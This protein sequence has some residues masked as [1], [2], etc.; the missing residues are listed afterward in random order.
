[1]NTKNIH[2]AVFLVFLF[3]SLLI[4]G[5]AGDDSSQ[6]EPTRRIDLEGQKNFRDLGGYSNIYGESVRWRI[7]FRSGDLHDLT[8]ADLLIVNNLDLQLVIDFRSEEEIDARPDRLPAGAKALHDP[9]TIEGFEELLFYALETGDISELTVSNI[10]N[11]YENIYTDNIEQFKVMLSEVINDENRPV[12]IHC[13]GG[14]DR[15][16]F[17]AALILASLQIPDEIIF[18]DYLLSNEY[19]KDSTEESL[20]YF[21]NTIEQNTGNTPTEEDMERIRNLFQVR[22]AYMEA[23]FQN[24]VDKYETFEEYIVDGLEISEYGCL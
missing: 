1:M 2:H 20:D 17:G 9:I 21:R 15:T 12:L 3:T 11:L 5:C 8:D 19:M 23:A 22:Q 4:N 6:W 18:E 24:V 7:L 13:R 14:A 10:A 16:G